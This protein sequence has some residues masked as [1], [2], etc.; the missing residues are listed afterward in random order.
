[1][2]QIIVQRVENGADKA[3]L[4]EMLAMFKTLVDYPGLIATCRMSACY[5]YEKGN[6][7]QLSFGDLGRGST[8]S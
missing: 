8:T 2:L 1:M 7:L 3:Y 4:A 6:T 5:D